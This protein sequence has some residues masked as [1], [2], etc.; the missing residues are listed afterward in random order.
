MNSGKSE[1]K[2]YYLCLSCLLRLFL[3][4]SHITH[5]SKHCQYYCASSQLC[6]TE[7]ITKCWKFEREHEEVRIVRIWGQVG[8]FQ[9][10]HLRNLLLLSFITCLASCNRWARSTSMKFNH[11]APPSQ[12]R[13]NFSEITISS[14]SRLLCP[15]L[16]SPPPTN[17][18]R[19][20]FFSL[21][22][23]NKG[24]T[25]PPASKSSPQLKREPVRAARHNRFQLHRTPRRATWTPT[26]PQLPHPHQPP[27]LLVLLHCQ[28]LISRAASW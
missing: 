11:S 3:F 2:D 4:K 14:F 1:L 12:K 23:N 22:T 27:L 9:V 18:S 5:P 6:C 8:K 13:S 28:H 19:Q 10:L 20:D 21:V 26:P 24:R 16:P 15:P 17:V 25:A 7:H